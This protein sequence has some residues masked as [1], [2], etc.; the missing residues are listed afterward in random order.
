MNHWVPSDKKVRLKLPSLHPGQA[1][2]VLDPARIVVA[3]CGS[4]TGKTFGMGI[5]LILQAWNNYQSLNWWTAPSYRQCD[6]AEKLI[7]DL[8]PPERSGRIRHRSSD[9]LIE[10]LKSDGTVWSRIQFRSAD[11]PGSLRGEGVHAAVVDEAAFW[12]HDSFV[13]VMTTLTRT[14]GKLRIISTPKGRN[15]FYD[16]WVK[17]WDEDLKLHNPEYS[18]HKLPT[19]A[20]PTVPRESLEEFKKN[21]PEDVY[22][23]EILAEFLDD[24]AGVFK[25]IESARVADWLE[26]P[27]AN[28]RYVI[29]VDWAKKED[30]TV[31]MVMERDEDTDGRR[32][33]VHIERHNGLDWNTNIDMAIKCAKRWNNAHMM[34]DSTGVGDV[35]FDQVASVYP[36]V[37]GYNIFNNAE[38]VR[39]IQSLQFAFEQK[40][41]GLPVRTIK[42]PNGDVNSKATELSMLL[43]REL[44]QYGYTM[45]S[46]GK[47]IFSAPEG[48]H[49]DMVIALALANYEAQTEPLTYKASTRR[50]I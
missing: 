24:S 40:K 42:F 49:D 2:F 29:G 32:N 3:A 16:E 33:I 44:E 26:R 35:P 25:Y 1:Q 43:R 39:L 23:Q 17:G 37:K 14:R 30:Y 11:D 6:I 31:F 27:V 5:W 45:S 20:N 38:K 10:L 8:L 22:R 7:L 9:R 18:S 34:M 50:G 36:Y 47:F 15:W 13:S 28:V 46:Q 19:H 41:I 12:K 21:M 48:Y 4:K